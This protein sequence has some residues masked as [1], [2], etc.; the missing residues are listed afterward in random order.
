MGFSPVWFGLGWVFLFVCLI[1]DIILSEFIFRE[2]NMLKHFTNY[3]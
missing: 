2:N 3:D 1:L